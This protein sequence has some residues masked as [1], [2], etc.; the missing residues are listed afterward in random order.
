MKFLTL[1]FILFS[2]VS[3]ASDKSLISGDSKRGKTLYQQGDSSK[4]IVACITCH[5]PAGNSVVPI[6][7]KLSAQH[8]AYLKKQLHEFKGPSRNNVIMTPI[9]MALTE[10][11]I[12]DIS[13]YLFEQKPSPGAAEDKDLVKLGK[14]IYRSGIKEKKVPAC[15]GCHSPNGVGIPDKFSR[16]AGQHQVY[17]YA[18]LVNF[19]E[20]KRS[21]SLQMTTIG[22]RLSDEEMKAVADYIAGL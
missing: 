14:K 1:L 20:G 5:G 11:D 17:T 12:L 21:N 3:F 19:K 10:K 22:K 18:Q 15:A 2:F 4:G 13:I 16:L 8:T 9:S 7:P 6:N